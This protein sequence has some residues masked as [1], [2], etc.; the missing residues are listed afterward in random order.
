M[1]PQTHTHRTDDGGKRVLLIVG[2]GITSLQLT[3][4]AFKASWC[5]SVVFIQRSKK[6]LRHFDVESAWMY[7]TRKTP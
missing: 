4:R 5:Q 1:E 2:G 7:Q 3:L 6:L